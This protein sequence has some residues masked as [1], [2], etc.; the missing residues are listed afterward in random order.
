MPAVQSLAS[1]E[2]AGEVAA[3][4]TPTLTSIRSSILPENCLSAR[5]TTH[6]GADAEL[7]S[8]TIYVGAHPGQEERILWLQMGQKDQRLYP[9][10]YTLWQNPGLVPLLHTPGFVVEKLK[11]G[12]DLMTPGLMRGPPFPPKAKKS[13]LVAVASLERPTVPVVVGVCQIDVSALEKVQGAKGHAVR[14]VHWEGDEIWAWGSDTAGGDPAPEHIAGW[15]AAGQAHQ[16]EV[17]LK[18]I[19]LEDEEDEIREDE[20]QEEGGVLLNEPSQ[21]TQNTIVRN[22]DTEER[23]PGGSLEIPEP[24]TPEIDQAFHEAFLYAVYNAKKSGAPPHYGIDF[25]IQPS[26][27]ISNMIQP[28]LPA[29]LG[30]QAQ[31]YT[32]KKTSWKNAKKFIKHLEKEGVVKSKDRNGGETVILDIDFGDDQVT[33]FTP[34]RLLKAKEYGGGGPTSS[35]ALTKG[36]SGS[37]PSISQSLTLQTLIRPSS[38]LVPDLLPSKTEFYTPSQILSYIRTYIGNNANLTSHP[39]SARFIKLD[40]FLANNVLGSHTTQADTRALAAGEIAR[41]VLQKRVLEDHNLCMPYWVLLRNGQKWSA[42]DSSL[43]KPK[44]GPPPHVS[45]TTE[46]RTGTKT[47]TR[48]GN[49][50]MFGIHP[51][52]LAGDLQKKCASSTSVSQLMGGKPGMMEVLVQGDQRDVVE[53]ELGR[54]GVDRRWIEMVDKTK[55]KKGDGGGGR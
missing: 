6:A 53:K 44:S 2:N 42:S 11:T 8:G 4:S 40:P 41:D 52:A 33:T 49:M 21:E 45:V 13:A 31:N 7:V 29:N 46:K 50:E 1:E 16:V 18:K 22:G 51:D 12:A 14:G 17:D 37:D 34:Y 36:S 15:E 26:L 5:F 54:R 3:P 55:K 20:I 38:K 35:P 19:N 48:V 9:T 23:D 47:V 27:L 24:S 30:P 28:H 39:S 43:P 25:P 32:I 10:V